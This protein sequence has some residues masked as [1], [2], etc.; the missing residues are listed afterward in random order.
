MVKLNVISRTKKQEQRETKMDLHK[1]H[2]VISSDHHPLAQAREYQRAV[3]GAKIQKM[4]SQPFLYTLHGHSDGVSCLSK[5][6]DKIESLISGS[7]NGEIVLWDLTQRQKL[8]KID[9]FQSQV[10]DIC[11]SQQADFFL[12]AGDNN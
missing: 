3:V 7:F 6:Y 1:V 4:F 5:P 10:K 11:I 2:R 8:F 12:A 9:A